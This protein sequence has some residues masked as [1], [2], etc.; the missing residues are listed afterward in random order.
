MKNN[1]SPR[2]PIRSLTLLENIF[3]SIHVAVVKSHIG[4]A[5]CQ[6]LFH[7]IFAPTFHVVYFTALLIQVSATNEKQRHMEV[8]NRCVKPFVQ[9]IFRQNTRLHHALKKCPTTTNI[10]A[11][12]FTSSTHFSL[13]F[14]AIC[15]FMYCPFCFLFHNLCSDEARPMCCS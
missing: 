2:F 10:Q 8:V 13:V 9:I 3:F 5:K 11:I 12:T 15:L 7:C 6:C 4:Y 14:T 1:V